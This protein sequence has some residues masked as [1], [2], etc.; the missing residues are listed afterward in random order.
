MQDNR[1]EKVKS[2]CKQFTESGECR[3]ACPLTEPCKTKAG[4]TKSKFDQRM[5]EAAEGLES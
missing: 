5:N 3:R 2:I 4:D 1:S